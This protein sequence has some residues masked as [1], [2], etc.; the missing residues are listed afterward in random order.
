MSVCS[1]RCIVYLF[2]SRMISHLFLTSL[3]LSPC[4]YNLPCLT[5]LSDPLLQEGFV[6]G[7]G[8]LHSCMTAHG[9]DAPTFEKASN[10]DLKP[11]K[12]RVSILVATFYAC[13]S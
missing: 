4:C 8:S 10:V 1:R 12:V 13:R 9:P 2:F 6:P 3:M 5:V 7:G 11:A